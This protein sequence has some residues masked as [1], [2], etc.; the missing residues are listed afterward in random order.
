[1][2]I[3]MSIQGFLTSMKLE[4]QVIAGIYVDGMTIHQPEKGIT[5]SR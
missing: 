1:M 3:S 2:M 4:V 5:V